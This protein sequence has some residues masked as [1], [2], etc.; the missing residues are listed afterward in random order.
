MSPPFLATAETAVATPTLTLEQELRAR[1]IAILDLVRVRAFQ[2][3]QV[4]GGDVGSHWDVVTAGELL[5]MPRLPQGIL[6][7]IND[8]QS[9][10]GTSV[11]AETFVNDPF[12]FCERHLPDQ[13]AEIYCIGSWDNDFK[14]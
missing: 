6:R 5:R 3:Q 12:L 4:I 11:Y 7:S 9:I 8:A 10:E 2:R 14:P 1:G 13:E